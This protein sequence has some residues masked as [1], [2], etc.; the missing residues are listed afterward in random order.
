M[1]PRSNRLSSTEFTAVFS[2]GKRIHT[3]SF[4]LIVAPASGCKVA[5]VIPKK[6]IKSAVG[7][8]RL[9]RRLAHI[10]RSIV[11]ELDFADACIVICKPA[12][13]TGDPVIWERELKH[14]LG[15]TS[16]AR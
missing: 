9:R 8:N 11:I 10:I 14:G 6:I 5:V 13:L 4:Q 7:R 3:P 2:S 16:K 15:R 12:V 1:F